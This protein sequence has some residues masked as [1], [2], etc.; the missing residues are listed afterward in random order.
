MP[1]FELIL[2][3]EKIPGYRWLSSFI[4]L[5]NFAIFIFLSFFDA[6]RTGALAAIFLLILYATLRFYISRQNKKPFHF[7]EIIFFVLAGS[8]LVL[9]HYLL[10]VG[11]ILLGIFYHLALQKLRFVFSPEEVQKITFPKR[12]Y[13]W[14]SFTNVMIKDHILTMDMTNNKLIQLEIED[15]SIIN[16][17]A[18]NEFVKNQIAAQ[19]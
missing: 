14:N 4:V 11:C 18:F 8:W 1:R 5:L 3:N 6:K 10:M 13:P 12:E 7:D 17:S 9:Q 16:E 2:R 15:G 19:Q